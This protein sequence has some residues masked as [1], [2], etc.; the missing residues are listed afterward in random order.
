MDLDSPFL[1]TLIFKESTGTLNEREVARVKITEGKIESANTKGILTLVPTNDVVAILPKLPDSGILYQLKDVEQAIRLL[2]SLPNDLKQRSESSM[3]TLQK[4]KDLRKSAEE[5]DA[6]KVVEEKE[7][8]RKKAAEKSKVEGEQYATW[9]KNSSDFLKPRNVAE[10]D[11]LRH[12]GEGFLANKSGDPVKVYDSLAM[13]SQILPIEKGGPLPNLEKLN[14]IQSKVSPDDLIVWVVVGILILSFFGLLIGLNSLLSGFTRAREGSI[15]GGIIFCGIG[16]GVLVGLTLIWWPVDGGGEL[17]APT[18]ASSMERVILFAKNSVKPIY[19]LPNS[20][21]RVSA[22]DFTASILASLSVS[23]EPSGMFK[24][25]LK[26]GKL[27]VK[28]DRWSWSQPVTALGIPL[29]VCFLFQGK[30]P[31]GVEWKEIV[32]DHVSMG[33]IKL[34]DGL[35]S[36]FSEGMKASMQGGLNAGGFSGIKVLQEDSGFLT[37]LTPSGGVK[38]KVEVVKATTEPEAQPQVVGEIYQK[39]TTAEAL[40]RFV[41]EGKLSAF[42]GKFVVLD[43]IV[44][45]VTSGSE[46]SGNVHASKGEGVKSPSIKATEEDFDIFYLK[47]TPRIKCF[48][49]SEKTFVTDSRRDIYVGPKANIVN[50]E[51]LIKNGLRVKFKK[52]GR[53]E[54]L[55]KIGEIEIYGVRLDSASD[56]ECYEPVQSISF[57]E[58]PIKTVGDPDFDLQAKATSGLPVNYISSNPTV[59]SIKRNRV[60]ILAPGVTTITA[61]Q[62]GNEILPRATATQILTVDPAPTKK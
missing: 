17:M 46:F 14:E 30:V 22:K 55:N 56:I 15:L 35:V 20:E 12:E 44:E 4:W 43:G 59:A 23:D 33:H 5:A 13:L 2:E 38:P 24:G 53:V 51:P 54:G 57:S 34:P 6:R 47:S 45:E 61:E 1:K 19:Y 25:R 39:E 26:K 27:W 48:I 31:Q 62:K 7:V 28:N 10:L 9:I 37:L 41:R 32:I 8:A 50:A 29:P 16:I 3:E 11:E 52:E 40:G 49:K 58:L 42:A 36:L 21:F 18:V 60:T